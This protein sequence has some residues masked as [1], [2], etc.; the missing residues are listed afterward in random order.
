MG[1]R[2]TLSNVS[3]TLAGETHRQALAYT[4]EQSAWL[5]S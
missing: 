1:V 3:P 4:S 5:V 2:T